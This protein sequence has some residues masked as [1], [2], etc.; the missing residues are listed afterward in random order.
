MSNTQIYGLEDLL[1]VM[2]RLRD[3]DTGCPWDKKQ[4][5]QSIVPS[6]LEEIYELIDAIERE[7]YPHLKE[8]LGDLLFQV[9]FYSQLGK[10]QGDFNFEQ[11]VDGLVQKLLRRHP[12]VFPKGFIESVPES[13]LLDEQQI[14][15][16]WELIKAQ[17]RKAKSQSGLLA[18]I[19]VALPAL[20]RAGK[21]QK[22]AASVDFDWDGIHGV[23]TKLKEEIAELEEAIE[24]EDVDQQEQELGD[25]LFACVNLARH[26]EKDPEKCLRR[27]NRKFE[28]RFRFIEEQLVE[29]GV[30][31]EK[32]GIDLMD[33]L[34]QQA[35]NKE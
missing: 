29:Q 28:S 8:E 11:V 12:H 23:W 20:I 2:G 33:Q 24:L 4:D 7:D 14:K 35:K 16:N 9:V 15:K 25:L 22:R 6:T 3:P 18:D 21:L 30:A 34:W 26:L 5:L 31:I 10:E 17:E 1:V 32:A 13:K 27:S 19:P